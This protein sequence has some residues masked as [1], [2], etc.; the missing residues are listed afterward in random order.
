MI[1]NEDRLRDDD[2]VLVYGDDVAMERP[3]NLSDTG[4]IN[5]AVRACQVSSMVLYVACR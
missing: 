5:S 4:S 3:E 1:Q 2:A